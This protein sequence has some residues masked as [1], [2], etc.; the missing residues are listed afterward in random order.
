MQKDYLS[1]KRI[2]DI[3]SQHV[4]SAEHLLT[5]NAE[6]VAADELSTDTLYATTSLLYIAFELTLKA[7]LLSEYRNISQFKKLSDLIA[8]NRHLAF[9]KEELE[10]LSQLSRQMAFRKGIDNRLWE[11]REE[12]FVF[13]KKIMKLYLRLQQQLPL[14]L[15]DFYHSSS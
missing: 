5:Q 12:Q 15:C 11:T 9:S 7:C 13:V 8:A 6:I 1:P 4:L 14:E 10:L 3:A 2:L